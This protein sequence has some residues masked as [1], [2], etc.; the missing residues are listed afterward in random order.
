[1]LHKTGSPVARGDHEE[2]GSPGEGEGKSNS[3]PELH[4]GPRSKGES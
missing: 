2:M 3:L 4:V 1:M